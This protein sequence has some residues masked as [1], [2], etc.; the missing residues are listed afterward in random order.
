MIA[1]ATEISTVAIV[2]EMIVDV[3]IVFPAMLAKTV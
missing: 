2:E 1:V 3:L